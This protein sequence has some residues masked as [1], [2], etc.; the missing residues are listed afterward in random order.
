MEGN[1]TKQIKSFININKDTIK[2]CKKDLERTI[3][4]KVIDNNLKIKSIGIIV[5]IDESKFGK[6]KFH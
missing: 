3:K 1:N 2:K 5:E 6:R 4:E